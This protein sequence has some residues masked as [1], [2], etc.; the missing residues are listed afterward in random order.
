MSFIGDAIGSVVGGITGSTKAGES[1]M[2]GAQVT[3]DAQREALEYLKE[4]EQL[5]QA[6]REA[7]L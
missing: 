5:P 2:Q 4:T 6:M 7:G 3:A 1:A